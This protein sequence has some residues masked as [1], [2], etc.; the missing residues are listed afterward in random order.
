MQAMPTDHVK[1]PNPARLVEQLAM[2]IVGQ[3]LGDRGDLI[4]Q[5]ASGQPDFSIRYADG[6]SAVGEVTWHADPHIEKMWDRVRH[7]DTPQQV[8]LGD[9]QGGWGARLLADADIR[10][11]Y[12]QLPRLVAEM[13][14]AGLRS[15]E[16]ATLPNAW[17]ITNPVLGRLT[18][19]GASL[20]LEYL[21][22]ATKHGGPGYVVFFPPSTPMCEFGAPDDLASWIEGVLAEE[23]YADVPRKLLAVDADERHVF[24]MAGSATPQ[25]VENRL[26]TLSEPIESRAPKLPTGL[27]HIWLNSRYLDPNVG[28]VTAHWSSQ[29]SWVLVRY[30][31]RPS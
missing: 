15:I 24:V 20:G 3:W 10:R 12:E 18:S 22:K 21:S 30:R 2:E 11:L 9:G 29:A 31:D 14:A 25:Q 28:Y 6:R 27:T 5:S 17:R 13:N 8:L 1:P 23:R 26:R 19:A 16:P 4:D 7:R